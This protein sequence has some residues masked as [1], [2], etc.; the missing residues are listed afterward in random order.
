MRKVLLLAVSLLFYASL[1][2]QNRLLNGNVTDQSTNEG[3]VG[4][5]VILKGTQT[6]TI[7]NDKGEFSL[8]IPVGA[9]TLIVSYVGYETKFVDITTE[10]VINIQLVTTQQILKEVVVVGYGTQIK[11]QL[12]GSISA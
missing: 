4:V 9:A 7:T 11:T 2:A 10:G 5:T 12:T 1:F 3:L 6:A 8:S